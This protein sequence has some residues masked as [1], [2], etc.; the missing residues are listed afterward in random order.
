MSS[1]PWKLHDL[2]QLTAGTCL[3]ETLEPP[4]HVEL[5]K[6]RGYLRGLA[7]RPASTILPRPHHHTENQETRPRCSRHR[8]GRRAARGRSVKPRESGLGPY[9]LSSSR[10][11]AANPQPGVIGAGEGHQMSCHTALATSPGAQ[12]F[13]AASPQA[14]CIDL[15][16]QPPL[17]GLETIQVGC[18][19]GLSRGAT[20]INGG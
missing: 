19:R 7:G 11:Q 13:M 17:G 6:L 20:R 3:S 12:A 16:G 18:C 15:D 8:I 2:R 1:W 9:S 5:G 14:G 4:E 10:D